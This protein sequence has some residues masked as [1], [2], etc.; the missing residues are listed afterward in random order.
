MQYTGKA[1]AGGP[2]RV[3]DA[4]AR[5]LVDRSPVPLRG[6]RVLDLGAGTGSASRAIE[7]A[8]G[9]VVAVDLEP[10]MLAFRHQTRPP[11]V[12]AEALALPFAP[13]SFDAVVAAFVLNH[14]DDAAGVL[15]ESARVL[16]ADG[17]LLLIQFASWTD[18]L[19]TG[20]DEVLQSYGYTPPSS[21]HRLKQEL[22]PRV[23]TT[24]A[25]SALT[26]EAS[27]VGV[28]VAVEDVDVGAFTARGL[29]AY[30]LGLAHI[31]P[32]VAALDADTRARLEADA[33]AAVG[34]GRRLRCRVILGSAR[35]RALAASEERGSR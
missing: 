16:R 30:R 22:E 32:F 19:K 10:A 25:L 7:A 5:I 18:P 33:V 21:Y 29:A 31:A 26:A 15:R 11:A 23:A 35:T 28:Q 13:A 17:A 4:L 14:V 20:V 3:Y 27:L 24:Q 6:A 8:G 9:R 12:V 2:E 1:W 34:P